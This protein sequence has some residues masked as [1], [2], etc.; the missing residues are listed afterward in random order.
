MI[1]LLLGGFLDEARLY[2]LGDVACGIE[3]NAEKFCSAGAAIGA[4]AGATLIVVLH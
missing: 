1:G 3:G 2:G 4:I